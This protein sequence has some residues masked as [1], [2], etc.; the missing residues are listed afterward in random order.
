MNIRIRTSVLAAV[1]QQSNTKIDQ[2]AAAGLTLLTMTISCPYD[3]ADG[4]PIVAWDGPVTWRVT[5][6]PIIKLTLSTDPD[7]DGGA[8]LVSTVT[9]GQATGTWPGGSEIYDIDPHGIVT[10]DAD[11]QPIYTGS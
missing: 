8:V 5:T 6:Y 1:Q 7:I 9:D 3:L 4:Q 2:C 11:G 10:T